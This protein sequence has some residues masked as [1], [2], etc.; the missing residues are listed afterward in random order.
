[1]SSMGLVNFLDLTLRF[2]IVLMAFMTSYLL[3]HLDADVIRSR[4]YVSF[5]KLK[6][7]FV[8]LT[9]GFILNLFEVLISIGS[10]PGSTDDDGIN[11]ILILIFQFTLFVFLYHIFVAIKVPDRRIL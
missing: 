10:A 2:G 7:Y 1:M 11:S 6:K 4:I 9:F 3:M 8:L 5:N